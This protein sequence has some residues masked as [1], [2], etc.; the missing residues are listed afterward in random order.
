MEKRIR[1]YAS[2]WEVDKEGDKVC[3]GTF[4]NSVGKKVPMLY[5]HYRGVQIGSWE[6]LQEDERGL[7]VEGKLDLGRCQELGIMQEIRK[8]LALSVGMKIKQAELQ[9]EVRNI[10]EA[11]LKEISIFGMGEQICPSAV[12]FE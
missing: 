3:R 10:R 7:Y 5:K 6:L 11:E 8:P 1:G 2:V 9:N 12:V 4:A